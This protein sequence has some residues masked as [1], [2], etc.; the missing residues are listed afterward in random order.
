MHEF[1][2]AVSILQT[3]LRIAEKNKAKKIL[4]VHLRVGELTLLNIEQLKFAFQI[5]SQETI[6]S[7]AKLIIETEKVRIKCN[8]CGFEGEL[9]NL[10][11]YYPLTCPKCSSF[12]VELL[13]GKSLVLKEIKIEK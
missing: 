9:N 10:G 7:E 4:E 12:N 6:A 13:G 8:E 11:E 1:S 3:I 2:T 5:A